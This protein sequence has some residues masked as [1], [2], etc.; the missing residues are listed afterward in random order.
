MAAAEAAGLMSVE[1]IV[2]GYG[3]YALDRALAKFTK[4]VGNSGVLGEAKGR[5]FYTPPSER[6]RRKKAWKRAK[7]AKS[8][9][10]DRL[11]DSVVVIGTRII[12]G[13]SVPGGGY[14]DAPV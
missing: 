2:E 14:R 8:A 3:Q 13:G 4:K 10:E 11:A 5:R 9:Q 12:G 7:T 6:R 1:V